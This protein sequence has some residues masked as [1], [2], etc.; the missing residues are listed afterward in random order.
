MALPIPLTAKAAVLTD[1]S[2]DYVVK[3]DHPVKQPSELSPGECLVKLEYSGVCHSDLHV[4]K[5]EWGRKPELPLVGGHEGVGHVVA[6][7]EHSEVGSIKIGDRVGVKWIGTICMRCAPINHHV[8]G[9]LPTILGHSCEMCR[10]G[11][12]SC[13]SLLNTPEQRPDIRA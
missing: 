6:I 7:G 2:Q 5:N 10:K 13:T 3:D 4:R 1:I 8:Q 12:E 11:Y 9:A